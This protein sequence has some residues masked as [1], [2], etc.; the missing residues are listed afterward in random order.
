MPTVRTRLIQINDTT[1]QILLAEGEDHEPEPGS[2]VLVNGEYGTAW[3]RYFDDGLW[4]SVRGGRGRT[5][6]EMLARQRNMFLAYD[7]P[8]RV[9]DQVSG[10]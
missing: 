9:P 6:E 7:A 8:I 5:W 1:G 10:R 4:H 3:Q 2:V